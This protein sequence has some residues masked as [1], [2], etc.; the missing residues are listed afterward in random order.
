MVAQIFRMLSLLERCKVSELFTKNRSREAP[1]FA[2]INLLGKCNVDCYFCL[3]KDIETW[4]AGKNQLAVPFQEWE[5][6]EQFLTLCE[7]NSI[8][9]LYV[10]GQNTDSLQYKYLMDLIN[11]LHSRNFK[12]GLRTNGYLA[13][14][15]L[16]EINSCELS[17]GYSIHTLRP[18]TNQIIMHR[19]NLPDWDSILQVTERPRVQI[20]VTR[21]NQYEVLDLIKW[22][23]DYKH[24]RYIQ[25]RRVSTDL[26]REMLAPD[27]V[28]YDELLEDIQE[29]YPC[30]ETL[31]DSAQVYRIHGMPVCC[32]Q[33]TATSINS[34]NYFTD[35]VVSTEYFIVEGYIKQRLM[36]LE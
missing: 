29:Q 16:D 5:N 12:V 25:L 4:L 19:R 10:T 20:V 18:A 21:Y 9:K 34:F 33:T 24:I 15:R 11:Y 6:F 30:E 22:L 3:G 13:L 14:A 7:H 35:G 36:E 8:N 27:A 2:N 31:W 1:T 17:T 26:R 28:A 32:W 23:A